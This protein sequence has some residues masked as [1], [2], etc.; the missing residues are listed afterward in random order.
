MIVKQLRRNQYNLV[1]Q[2]NSEN[3][4]YK[5]LCKRNAER[6][7]TVYDPYHCGRKKKFFNI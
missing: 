4:N 6:L 2:T 3:I 7:H 5:T 1:N